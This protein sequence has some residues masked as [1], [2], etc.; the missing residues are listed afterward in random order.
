MNCPAKMDFFLKFTSL[1][2]GWTLLKIINNFDKIGNTIVSLVYTI[3]SL[4]RTSLRQ[5]IQVWLYIINCDCNNIPFTNIWLFSCKAIKKKK[6]VDTYQLKYAFHSL[7]IQSN[8]QILVVLSIRRF[9]VYTVQCVDS[10]M[11][12]KKRY[13]WKHI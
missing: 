8:R 12:N 2:V 6:L 7:K 3:S 4:Y 1:S 11:G 13:F 9:I 10:K 5:G